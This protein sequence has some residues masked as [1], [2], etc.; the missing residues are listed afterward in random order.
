MHLLYCIVLY[1]VSL[2]TRTRIRIR[3]CVCVVV[4]VVVVADEEG[5]AFTVCRVSLEIGAVHLHLLLILHGAEDLLRF[6]PHDPGFVMSV[7]A[8][9][10][11]EKATYQPVPAPTAEPRTM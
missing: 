3:S 6:S 5:S 2:T 8:L 9:F 10:F 1:T 4:V 7:C 11:W